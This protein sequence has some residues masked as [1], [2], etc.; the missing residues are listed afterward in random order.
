[1]E[2]AGGVL[3][4]AEKV[5]QVRFKFVVE[6]AGAQIVTF[7]KLINMLRMSENGPKF[8]GIEKFF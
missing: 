6:M 2:V 1:M 3:V 8:T 4:V 7:R 5:F